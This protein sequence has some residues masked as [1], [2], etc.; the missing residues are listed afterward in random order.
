[1]CHSFR[2]E[3]NTG[4]YYVRSNNKTIALWQSAYEISLQ[5]PHLDDQAVFWHVIRRSQN[6]FVTHIGKCENYHYTAEML[7]RKETPLI[8]C[9]LDNCA[10]SS[11]MLSRLWIPE[12]TYEELVDIIAIRKEKMCAIHANYIKGNKLKMQKMY[13]HNLWLAIPEIGPGVTHF[14]NSNMISF[15]DTSSSSDHMD[16][17]RNMTIDFSQFDVGKAKWTGKCIKWVP[18]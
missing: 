11:G 4:F 17:I 18:K 16:R 3:G 9:M 6:P 2:T 7:A 8:A 15:N 14:N 1:M 5:T 12:F 10:F 13:E